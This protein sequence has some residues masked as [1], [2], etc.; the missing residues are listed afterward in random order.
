MNVTNRTDTTLTIAAT[1]QTVAPGES[2]K[3]DN[4]L[5]A[6]LCEQVKVWCPTPS[7]PAGKVEAVTA[8][9]VD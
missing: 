3:V 6:S 4:D 7:K 2:V 5:G 9:D 8:K 1:G